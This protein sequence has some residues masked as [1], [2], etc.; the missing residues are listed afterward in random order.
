ML[1]YLTSYIYIIVVVFTAGLSMDVRCN[2]CV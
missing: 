2:C 1:T